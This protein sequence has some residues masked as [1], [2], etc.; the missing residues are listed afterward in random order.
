MPLIKDQLDHATKPNGTVLDF[1][2]G[3]GT[4]GQAVLELNTDD[5]GSKHGHAAR[6][7]SARSDQRPDAPMTRL[8][9]TKDE[10]KDATR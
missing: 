7:V 2:A 5:G 9:E 8:L 4:T 1:S 3:L 6:A 10:A